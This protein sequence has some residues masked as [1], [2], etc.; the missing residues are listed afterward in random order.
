MKSNKQKFFAFIFI[1][2]MIII[3]NTQAG[4]EEITIRLH[5]WSGY[6]K[7]YVEGFKKIV[8][9]KHHVDVNME[10]T[11]VSD[12]SEFWKLSRKKKVDIISPAHNI[13]R[14]PSWSFV[15]GKIIL[16]INL[17]NIPSYKHIL[18]VLQK[19]EFVT[20][21]GKVY[22]VPY[23]MGLYGLAYNTEKVEEPESWNVLWKDTSKGLYTISKSYSDCNIYIT[24][25]VL[26]ASYEFL[27]DIDK[28]RTKLDIG[29]TMLELRKSHLQRKLDTLTDNAYSL[30][31]GTANPD[32]FDK[33]AYAAT[34]GYAIRKANN[35]GFK[36]KM[37]KPREGTTMWVDHWAI[38]YAVKNNPLKKKLCEEWIDYC[39]SQDLQIGVIRNWGVSPVVTN[40]NEL[41]TEDEIDTFNVGDNEYWKT[42]SPWSYQNKRTKNSYKILWKSTID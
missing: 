3:G 38:T 18:P 21:G 26:G 39:L 25:L 5:C 13:P 6:A 36:W 30:W 14:S 22:G 24:S 28:L 23:T 9:N 31:E 29:K 10:I 37:A 27:Y 16:P 15:S 42:L 35:E 40:I 41:I 12:P 17:N 20:E 32:E 4:A 1:T 34:W 33:L 7:P 8:K 19:N 2:G 11:N